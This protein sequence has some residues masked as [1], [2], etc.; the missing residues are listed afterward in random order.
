MMH[1]I[2]IHL[3]DEVYRRVHL[4]ATCRSI[5]VSTLIRQIIIE[6][7]ARVTGDAPQNSPPVHVP[8]K[9]TLHK[10]YQEYQQNVHDGKTFEQWKAVYFPNGAPE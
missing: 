2:I 8:E 4:E 7:H 5:G 3:P 6:A 10:K 1:R 9:E